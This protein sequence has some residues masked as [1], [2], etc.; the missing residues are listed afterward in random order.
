MFNRPLPTLLLTASVLV[1]AG[2]CD[3]GDAK[4]DADKSAKADTKKDA[5]KADGGDEAKADAKEEPAAEPAKPD[6]AAAVALNLDEQGRGLHGYDPVAYHAEGGAPT[7]GLAEHSVEGGGGTWLF[8]SAENKAKFEAE[9]DK[10]APQNGGYCTF[11]V[12]VGKKFDGD[13]KVWHVS[14]DKLY[15]FLNDEVKGKFLQDE[16]GNLEKVASNWPEIKD[17]QASEL[18]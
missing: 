13:P 10:Y 3:K 16:P 8:A 4:K 14:E 5:A 1:L 18:E 9:P 12:V 6:A 15:V 11:G 2:A 17:K 7:E